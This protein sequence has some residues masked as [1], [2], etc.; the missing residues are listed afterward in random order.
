MKMK[1]NQLFLYA[2]FAL[3][4]FTACQDEEVN[5]NNPDT[6]EIIQP[7]SQ[8]AAFM[9]SV[10]A[11]YGAYDD[12]LDESSC[13]SIELP[14]TIIV[15]DITI[16]IETLEDIEGLEELFEAFE[17]E[18]DF[19]DFVF[20]ITIIFSD[21]SEIVIENLDQLETFIEECDLDEDGVDDD[22]IQCVDFVY[23]I[24][25]SVFNTAFDIV[26]TVTIENDEA[27]Y[28][29]LDGLDD[30]EEALIVS[31]NYPVTLV[32]ANGE[33]ITVT[34]NQELADAIEAAEDD[35]ED[36]EEEDI[37]DLNLEDLE[38]ILLE[39]PFDVEIYDENDDLS[40]TLQLV[41]N[42]SGSVV[43]T[44]DVA[45][46]DEG[47]WDLLET[48]LETKLI[49]EGL[50]TFT[51][52]NGLWLLDECDEDGELEFVKETDNGHFTMELEL[53]CEGDGEDDCTQ[54]EVSDYLLSCNIIPTVDG[55]TSPLTTFQF[56][57]DNTIFTMYQG[58]LPHSG[59]WDISSDEDGIFIVINFTPFIDQYYNGQ[60]YLS[61]CDDNGLV[62][63]QGDRELILVCQA[64]EENPFECFGNYDL[65]VCDDE[66]QD[67]TEAFD[68]NLI[69][70]NCPNDDVSY[71]FYHTVEDA[72]NQTNPLPNPFNNTTNPQTI[73]S[74]VSLAGDPNI[75][76]IFTHD[77][78]VEDCTNYCTE[79]DVDGILMECI[80]NAVNYNGSDNLMEWNFDFEGAN[81]IVVIYTDTETIDATWITS[82]SEDGVVVT[83]SNVAGPNI[84]A[85]NGEWLVVECT[86]EA[87]Q[88]QRGNDFLILE[89]NCE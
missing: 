3:L 68:L 52:A 4:A 86:E 75:F 11:N 36:D 54:E 46:V 6:Q 78:I 61:E 80:W 58:D 79:E 2:F 49:I 26:E 83:F 66:T 76:E 25:F 60:W 34:S 45:V 16:V 32:Y 48:D 77:L 24:T 14:V 17:D 28:N 30:D 35:C 63:H 47:E 37:C 39:C 59:T 13:F 72:E 57:E 53:D 65:S 22:I 31:L 50:Q 21:Y 8:V 12:I 20:P 70:S 41:F 82:Q 10:T 1:I 15:G 42:A 55:Y 73:Y 23:P 51:L 5:V 81:N 67:T 38:A 62:F 44:G 40:D 56:S 7:D 87:L 19:F 64:Y 9:S 27:L 18:D 88:L 74:R 84:Q 29:F 71:E 85:I 43:V 89:R 33:T 69:F